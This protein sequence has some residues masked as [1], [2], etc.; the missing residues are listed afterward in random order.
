[1]KKKFIWTCDYCGEE[2][3]TKHDCDKHELSC[4]KNP[5]NNEIIFKI[6]KPGSDVVFFLASLFLLIYF[7]TYFIAAS[8]ADSNGLPTRNILQ[9]NKW[10]E[11]KPTVTPMET[12]TP[13]P[14]MPPQVKPK[15]QANKYNQCWF[16]N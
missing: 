5:E 2:Y 16:S 9:P 8:Y 14:S 1:M 13:L 15:I 11:P 3:D 12:P 6:K 7:L 4:K 10:F